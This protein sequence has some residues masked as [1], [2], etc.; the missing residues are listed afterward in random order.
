MSI[1]FVGSPYAQCGWIPLCQLDVCTEPPGRS[2]QEYEYQL[3][4]LPIANQFKIDQLRRWLADS[5]AGEE[6]YVKRRE[7]SFEEFRALIDERRFR[8]VDTQS[9]EII[10]ATEMV[11]YVAVSYVWGKKERATNAFVLAHDDGKRMV[12]FQNTPA[13][14]RD[15]IHL[16]SQLNLQYIWIDQLCVTQD[17]PDDKVANIRKMG[18][19]YSMATFT[20]VAAT[21]FDAE[22]GL[23]RLHN[24]QRP[25]EMELTAK[26]Q[27]KSISFLPER[28]TIDQI[29][30]GTTW[31]KRGWTF[32][33]QFL[34]TR[35]II[36]TD[37]EVFYQ[38]GIR[39]EREAYKLVKTRP[40]S[41]E[42][43]KITMPKAWTFQ[44]YFCSNAR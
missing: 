3:L 42:R 9:G 37:E 8:V 26:H 32:Q 35:R 16:V 1:E 6:Q 4:R 39:E 29:V 28:E 7:R 5:D 40:D 15:A 36:F 11:S 20:L 38:D 13:T 18:V 12:D 30:Q 2:W 19:I 41:P 43:E 14:L 27:G 22:A 10:E 17:D 21:G 44:S 24:R 31:A 34:S 25:H 23:T 33:E